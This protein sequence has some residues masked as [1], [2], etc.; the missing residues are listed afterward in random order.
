MLGT[1][2]CDGDE[3]LD[4]NLKRH[5]LDKSDK[6]V[7]LT[8]ERSIVDLHG[9]PPGCEYSVWETQVPFLFAVGTL[10]P[11]KKSNVIRIA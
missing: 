4:D 5:L 7:E 6:G 8:D 9:F 1:G 10:L 3:L 11:D 2:Q